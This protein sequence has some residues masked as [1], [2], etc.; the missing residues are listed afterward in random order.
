M[1]SV[2]ISKYHGVS[3]RIF[4]DF[5]RQYWIIHRKKTQVQIKMF[6]TRGQFNIFRHISLVQLIVLLFHPLS[7]VL[8]SQLVLVKLDHL[9]WKQICKCFYFLDSSPFE[10]TWCSPLS[11]SPGR[12]HHCPG[13]KMIKWSCDQVMT[14]Q[15][16]QVITFRKPLHLPA[17]QEHQLSRIIRCPDDLVRLQPLRK[18]SEIL[19]SFFKRSNLVEAPCLPL[20][21][22]FRLLV[23]L[24]V[25][26]PWPIFDRYNEMSRILN[27]AKK[28]VQGY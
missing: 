17:D 16:D 23:F 3:H 9:G 21:L 24:L 25:P 22:P 15:D 19:T 6:I 13:N 20:V 7:C 18:E 26:P 4:I 27:K 28:V 14:K 1:F 12:A 2:C 10:D 5:S 8:P 11:S